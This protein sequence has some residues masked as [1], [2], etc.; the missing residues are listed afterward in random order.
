MILIKIRAKVRW[1]GG[2]VPKWLGGKVERPVGTWGLGDLERGDQQIS[3]SS[4]QQINPMSNPYFRFK[5][6][7]VFHDKCAMKVGTDGVLLGAWAS[8]DKAVDVLDV[9]TG[10][11]LIALMVAQR[12]P[13]ARIVAIDVDEYAVAQATENVENSPFADR[14]AVGLWDFRQFVQ[15]RPECF[16]L[17]VCNPPYFSDSLLPPDK[18]RAT[19]RHSV[20][21]TLD[22]LLFSARSCLRDRGVLSLILPYDKKDELDRLCEKHAFYMKRKTIVYPLPDSNPKRLLIEL[23]VQLPGYSETSSLIIENSRHQYT[24]DFSEMVSNFYIHL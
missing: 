11:G 18:A 10:T 1:L 4:H 23:T 15:N 16:D 2:S 8:V 7:T 14:I 3:K 5:Q 17:I 22:E 12:N 24:K 6:F 9:G 21:L 13:L 20:S 19:A